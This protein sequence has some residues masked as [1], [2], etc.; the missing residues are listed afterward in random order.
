MN[1]FNTDVLVVGAGPAGLTASALLARQG[2]PSITITKYRSTANGP[3]AHLANQRTMEVMRDLGLESRIYSVGDMVPEVPDLVWVTSLADRE[4]ARRRAWGTR[5]DR[6]GEYEASSPSTHVSIAQHILEPVILRGA[7]DLGADIRFSTELLEITQDSEGIAAKVLY[8]PTGHAYTIR[9]RYVIGADGG[10]STVAAQSGIEFDGQTR[11]GYALNAYIQADLEHLVAHRPGMLYWTNHPGREY[12]FGSGAF[13]LVR[14]WDEWMV[15]FSYDPEADRLDD[16]EEAVL[17]RIRAAIGDPTVDIK[18]KNLGKWEL[19]SLVARHYRKGRVFIAGDAAHRHTPANGLG[20]NTSIQDSYNLAWKLS[21]VV[22]GEADEALLDSY[23]AERLPVGQQVVRRAT[24]SIGLVA[25]VPSTL[26]IKAGQTEEE[27]WA[28]LDSF[29]APTAD[30]R[31]R[32]SNLLRILDSYDYG[33]NCYGVEMGQHY[34]TGAVVTDGT[35]FPA[36][37]DDSELHYQPATHPGSHLPHVWL[38]RHGIPIS[39]LDLV[40][41]DTWALI[42]GVEGAG[43]VDAA[44]Q[45]STELGVEIAATAVGLGLEVSD[46]YGDWAKIREIS[47]GGALL[48]RPDKFVAWRAVDTCSAPVMEL[49]DAFS[50]LLRPGA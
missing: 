37:D 22:N 18:I 39:T 17:P 28:A 16:T 10:R 43:W 49:R 26:G 11:L 19:N 42:T 15:Q 31:S 1:E 34:E 47:D 6:K 27:G 36:R 3:R 20:S 41:A 29:Y 23:E 50:A 4:L 9:A 7:T 35:P 2:T 5:T 24:K 8:R 30:G 14:R 46:P 44:K 48:I 21:M 13:A 38:T 12:F 45:L 32:R 25:E 33:I 40:P